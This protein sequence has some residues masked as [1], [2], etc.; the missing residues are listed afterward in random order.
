[1]LNRF[2]NDTDGNV[3][4]MFAGTA[5]TLILGIGAAIDFG[6]ASNRKQ[7]LQDMIDAATLAAAKANSIDQSELQTVVDTVVREHNDCLLYTSPSPRD[8]G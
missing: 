1:M 8:R 5:L 2:K 4:M 6:S 3:A 7:D